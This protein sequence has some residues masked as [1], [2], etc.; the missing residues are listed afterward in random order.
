MTTACC[1]DSISSSARRRSKLRFILLFVLIVPFAAR[2]LGRTETVP[3]VLESE[4]PY[5]LTTGLGLLWTRAKRVTMRVEVK[6]DAS[7]FE[8]E[9]IE[10]VQRQV[11]EERE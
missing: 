5:Q 10:T 1:R 8:G 2:A 3:V 7:I 11:N 6:M 4:S 9:Y